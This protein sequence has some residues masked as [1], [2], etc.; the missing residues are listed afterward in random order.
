MGS[1]ALSMG[2]GIDARE[3]LPMPAGGRPWRIGW[4]SS[5]SGPD[6]PVY[7]PTIDIVVRTLQDLA[8]FDVERS[9]RPRQYVTDAQARVTA[10]ACSTASTGR[11]RWTMVKLERVARQEPATHR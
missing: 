6:D 8:R 10:L 3:P 2:A 5:G 11:Q 4:L 1:V 7:R 9:G